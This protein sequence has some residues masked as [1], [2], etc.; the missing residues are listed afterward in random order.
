MMFARYAD[1]KKRPTN[2]SDT[3][4]LLIPIDEGFNFSEELQPAD[5]PRSNEVYIILRHNGDNGIE[6]KYFRIS[7]EGVQEYD[8]ISQESFEAEFELGLFIDTPEELEK[9][10]Q[11][12][13]DAGI[14]IKLRETITN[15]KRCYQKTAAQSVSQTT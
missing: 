7:A 13:T 10:S 15:W 11:V 12:H 6:I 2:Y 5:F 1:S 4:E 14:T 8:P 9:L 3:I